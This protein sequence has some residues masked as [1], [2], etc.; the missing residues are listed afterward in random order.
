MSSEW[1]DATLVEF[2]SLNV[3]EI[4]NVEQAIA[5]MLSHS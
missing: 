1:A 2:I 4:R 3:Y 5:F